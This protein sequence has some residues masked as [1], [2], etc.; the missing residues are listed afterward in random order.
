MQ[1]AQLTKATLDVGHMDLNIILE[2]T[3]RIDQKTVKEMLRFIDD[4][5]EFDKVTG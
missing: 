1:V 4:V 2:A 5:V 3:G